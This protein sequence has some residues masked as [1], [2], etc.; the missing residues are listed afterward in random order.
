MTEYSLFRP[1]GSDAFDELRREVDALMNRV[2]TTQSAGRGVFPP[3]NL[4]ETPDAFLLTAELPGVPADAIQV[5]IEGATLTL[6][7]ERKIER[8]AEK[9]SVH[10]LERQAGVFRRAL[11]LPLPVVADQVE[12]QV[13]NGVLTLRLPKTPD[14]KP[15]QIAVKAA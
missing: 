5:S 4:Y 13:R 10:R 12:A 6:R 15:R 7:G 3:V 14:A 8:P 9:Q 2:A 1:G 11:E